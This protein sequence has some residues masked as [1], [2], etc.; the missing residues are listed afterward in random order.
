MIDLILGGARSGKSR[1]AEQRAQLTQQQELLK[2][3]ADTLQKL[4]APTSTT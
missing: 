4:Q 1:L 2:T 3:I